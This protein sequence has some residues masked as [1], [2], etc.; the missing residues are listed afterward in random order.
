MKNFLLVGFMLSFMSF[1]LGSRLLSKLPFYTRESYFKASVYKEKSWEQFYATKEAQQVV[2]PSNYDFHL[3]N[4]AFFYATN[5]LREEHHVKVL[6]FS[7]ALRDAATFHTNEM[8]T[9]KFFDHYNNSVVPKLRSPRQRMQF[10]TGNHQLGLSGENCDENFVEPYESLTYIQ[11]AERIVKDLYNSPPH[12]ANMLEKAYRY[13]GCAV[14]FEQP[15]GKE[16]AVFLKAT[17]NF[18]SNL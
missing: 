11:V 18:T 6:Q 3:L 9:K 12:K 1:D 4:A 2:D 14:I 15:R 13:Y 17:Q 8:I 7:G 5:K 10:F 16:Q